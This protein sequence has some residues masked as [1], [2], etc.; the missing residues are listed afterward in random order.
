MAAQIEITGLKTQLE[1]DTKPFKEAMEEARTTGEKEAERLGTAFSEAVTEGADFERVSDTL[2]QGAQRLGDSLS[3]AAEKAEGLGG[4]GE[5]LG[6]DVT[7]RFSESGEVI[8]EWQDVVTEAAQAGADEIE[9]FNKKVESIQTV[10]EKM[11]DIGGKLTLG[12]TAPVLAAGTAIGKMAVDAE[13]DLGRMQGQLGLTAEEAEELQEVAKGIYENGFGD[14]LSQCHQELTTLKQNLTSVND[15]SLESQKSIMEQILTVNDLFGTSTEEVARTLQIMTE[16]GLIETAEEG[17]DIITYGFQNGANYSVELLDVLSEYSPKFQDLGLDAQEAMAY[18][19]QGAENGAFNLDKVGDA[20]KEFSIR[21]VDGSDDTAAAFRALGLAGQDMSEDIEKAK[22]KA[23]TYAEKIEDLTDKLQLAQMKQS[24]FNEKTSES[25][26]LST[27]QTI[28]KYNE[29]LEEARIG[30]AETT[31]SIESME[32][33]MNSGKET[34]DDYASRFAQ[35]GETAKEAFRETLEALRSVEDP[36]ERQK[37]GVQLFG[38]MWEDM[39]EDA[40][41]SLADVEGGLENIEGAT[42]R[43]GEQINNSFSTRVQ[44]Q[45]REVKDSLLPLG[46]EMLRLA[47]ECMPDVKELI[48][49]ITD[50]LKDMDGEMAENILKWGGVA[51]AAGPVLKVLGSGVG[52]VGD[53]AKAFG[54]VSTVLGVSGG[55]SAAGGVGLLGSLGTLSAI[56][57]PVAGAVAAV[58]VAAYGVHE[59]GDMMNAT[60]LTSREEMSFMERTLADLNGVTTYTREELEEMGYVHKDFSENISPEFQQAVKDST[61]ELQDFDVYLNE[62]GFDDVL[63]EEESQEFN[64]KVDGICQGAIDTINARKDEVQTAMSE[65]FVDDGILSEAEQITLEFLDQYYTDNT[66]KIQNT[67]NAVLNIKEKALLEDRELNDREIEMING[68]LENIKRLELESIGGTQEEMLYAQNEFSARVSTL[69]LEDASKLIQEKAAQ[70]DEEIV[71]IQASY[72]TQIEL[73]RSKIYETEGEERRA[74]LT[75][76]EE[77]IQAKNEKIQQ[78]ND[79]YDSYLEIIREKNPQMAEE[80]NKYTGELLTNQDKANQER[81][82]Q[83]I[84]RWDGI[85]EIQESGIYRMRDKETGWY[86]DWAVLVDETTG[87]IVGM[88]EA[89]S[90]EVYAYSNTMAEDVSNMSFE[91]EESYKRIGLAIADYVDESGNLRN[92][93][94]E[95]VGSFGEVTR[96]ADGTASKLVEIDGTTYKVTIDAGNAVTGLQRVRQEADSIPREISITTRFHSSAPPNAMLKYNGIDRVPYDGYRAILHK[97][98]AVLTKEQADVLRNAEGQSTVIN[99]N[100]NYSFQNQNDIKYFMNQAALLIKGAQS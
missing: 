19:I 29:Q 69:T 78:Q 8:K 31:A 68:H 57:L 85:D 39:G 55:A 4:I 79:L 32:A 42:E 73:L 25:T 6:R 47:D 15:L 92:E 33:E 36:L 88:Y 77:N 61:K 91:N 56:A 23:N 37:I 24:E 48:G 9:N 2:S 49:E 5:T 63:T 43:A 84:E 27:Y 13:N 54:G 44:M 17:L 34:V 30:L 96:E 70:R 97:D 12:V 20:M 72:D 94:D 81:L 21:A 14:S 66:E 7:P 45:L 100:G 58:G 95:I 1:L 16:S 52:V 90:G 98:E 74:L 46:D 59:Y 22:E 28:Q 38:T 83:E 53:L 10:G 89:L 71:Q 60:V 67:K 99:F 41:L 76:I 11:S 3:D 75:S 64:V 26:K 40:I 35:G 51:A 18:L 82:Q 87:D 80:I 93:N 86:R 62:I 65:M 50:F